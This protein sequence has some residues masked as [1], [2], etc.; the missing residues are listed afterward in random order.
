MS[1]IAKSAGASKT[2]SPARSST[3][4]TTSD[5][6]RTDSSSLPAVETKEP[7]PYKWLTDWLSEIIGQGVQV[8]HVF[9]DL[10][11]SK[12]V[13]TVEGKTIELSIGLK[14]VIVLE[15]P[16]CPMDGKGYRVYSK[17]ERKQDGVP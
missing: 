6:S 11:A 9:S 7:T 4:P 17:E 12:Y 14:N 10:D 5:V 1:N 13:F 15:I 8:A 3:K 16:N 2:P